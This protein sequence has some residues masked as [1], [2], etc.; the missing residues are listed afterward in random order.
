MQ[1]L[2]TFTVG[3]VII[4]EIKNTCK[5]RVVEHL[6]A[7]NSSVLMVEDVGCADLQV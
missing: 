4:L 7:L 1:A 6:N 3:P 2:T 5:G